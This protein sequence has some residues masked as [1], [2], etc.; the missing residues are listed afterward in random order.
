MKYNYSLARYSKN[1]PVTKPVILYDL[2]S[3]CTNLEE[4][5]EHINPMNFDFTMELPQDHLMSGKDCCSQN[6]D[7]Q[8]SNFELTPSKAVETELNANGEGF[9]FNGVSSQSGDLTT[10]PNPKLRR[11][12][13]IS[14]TSYQGVISPDN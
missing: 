5:D 9:G 8:A 11:E 12:I 10:N 3:D 14:S 7:K 13:E 2:Y 6:A 4:C 1:K